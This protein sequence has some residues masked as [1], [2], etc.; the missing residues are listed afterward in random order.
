MFACHRI[1]PYCYVRIFVANISR[2]DL[3]SLYGMGVPKTSKLVWRKR[4]HENDS[5]KTTLSQVNIKIKSLKIKGGLQYMFMS[6]VDKLVVF[7]FVDL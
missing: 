3:D 5:L 2:G 1:K 4:C 6:N 7:T